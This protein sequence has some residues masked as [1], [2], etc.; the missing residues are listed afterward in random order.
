MYNIGYSITLC[1]KLLKNKLNKELEKEGITAAQFAVIKDIE[2]SYKS[3]ENLEN[4]TAVAIGDRL[5]M[6]KPTISGIINRLMNK[7]Y[8]ERLPHPTDKR[9]S[10]LKL[11]DNCTSKLQTFESTSENV[12]STAI[13]GIGEEDLSKFNEVLC[14][15][16]NNM[17]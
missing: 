13:K 9:A 1:S 8:I 5:D 11:T 3:D 2:I 10:I 12:V 16:I 4:I 6:D 14:K 15:L 17:K 7:G